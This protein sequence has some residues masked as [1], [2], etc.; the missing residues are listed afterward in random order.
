MDV[1]PLYTVQRA[2]K[3]DTLYGPTHGSHDGDVTVCGVTI[4]QNWYIVSNCSYG[5]INCM[6]C[7]AEVSQKSG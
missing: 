2:R 6:K 7:L 3:D 1:L 4:D 5:E